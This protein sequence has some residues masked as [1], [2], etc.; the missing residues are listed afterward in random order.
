LNKLVEARPNKV[1]VSIHFPERAAEVNRVIGH[2][3]E[4]AAR[5]IKSGI[6]LLVTRTNLPA[7]R[8]AAKR[9]RDAGIGNDRIVYLP[10]RG[11]DTPT[12]D[13]M[14]DVA[15]RVPFQSMSCLTKC[16]QSPRFVSVGWDK[17]VAW[18]S[19]TA[20]RRPLAELTFAGLLEATT[21]LGLE[22]CGGTDD[23]NPRPA[24]RRLPVVA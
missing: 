13:E 3:C 10:M 11:G 8:E 2:V 1:H 6:N 12:P 5:E 20:S 21:G 16:G 17:T 4:L 18:C 22:F 19:Y 24:A 7:A 23:P 15:G 9:V 14:A